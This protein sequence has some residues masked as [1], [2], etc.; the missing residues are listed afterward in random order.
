MRRFDRFLMLVQTGAMIFDIKG[1][2]EG[3]MAVPIL[4]QAMMVY[5][6]CVP[7]NLSQ[8]TWEFIE[9]I[10]GNSECPAWVQYR[11]ESTAGGKIEGDTDDQP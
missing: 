2:H 6:S 9:H 5:P 7:E 11:P 8:A 1:E 4:A 3:G 10:L